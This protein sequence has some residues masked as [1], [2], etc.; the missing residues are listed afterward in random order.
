MYASNVI[1][2]TDF[3]NSI[4]VHPL[5]DCMVNKNFVHK[6]CMKCDKIIQS[7][8]FKRK[9]KKKKPCLNVIMIKYFMNSKIT[10]M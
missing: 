6:E 2:N 4:I 3:Q 5:A 8:I 10:L 9:D 7:E 1:L